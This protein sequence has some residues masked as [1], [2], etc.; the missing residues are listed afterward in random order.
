MVTN[1]CIKQFWGYTNE[2]LYLHDVNAYTINNSTYAYF[3]SGGNIPTI[4]P[5][6]KYFRTFE[7]LRP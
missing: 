3:G 6:D 7:Q 5:A 4:L 1:Y 2:E